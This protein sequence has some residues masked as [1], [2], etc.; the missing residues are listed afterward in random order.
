MTEHAA[1][2]AESPHVELLELLAVMSSYSDEEQAMGGAVERAAQTL[3]AEVAAIVVDGRVT[4]SV[5]FPAKAV[6]EADV[7]AITRH[8]RDT[9]A[10]PGAGDCVAIAVEWGGLHRGHLVVARAGDGFSVEEHSVV[11]GMARLLSLT[12]TMLRTLQAEHA[13]RE[14]SERLLDSLRH[15]SPGAGRWRRSWT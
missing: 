3:E 7:L 11:R 2:G 15:P 5:G 6:P 1:G 4:A 14:R 10:V 9:L 13:M 12:L 8:E